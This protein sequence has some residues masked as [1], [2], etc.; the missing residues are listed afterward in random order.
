M[1]KKN[2]S[3]VVSKAESFIANPKNRKKSGDLKSIVQK[4]VNKM[5]TQIVYLSQFEETSI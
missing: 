4:K 5:I 3:F 2:Y 1:K